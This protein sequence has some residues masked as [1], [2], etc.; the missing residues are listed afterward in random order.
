M[1][2]NKIK[3]MSFRIL[4]DNIKINALD[5]VAEIPLNENI[6]VRIYH[7]KL[8]RSQRQSRLRW[9]WL[10]QLAKELVGRGYGYDKDKWNDYFKGKYLMPILIEQDDSY[11]EY[12]NKYKKLWQCVPPDQKHDVLMIIGAS[13]RTEDLKTDGMAKFLN[14]IDEYAIS[15]GVLLQTP[16]EYRDLASIKEMAGR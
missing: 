2:S 3:P 9:V 10:A 16:S 12:F 13:L 4:N 7:E 5:A 14:K 8:T 1:K 15:K 6:V 11:T